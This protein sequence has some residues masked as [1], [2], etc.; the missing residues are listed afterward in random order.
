MYDPLQ[1]LARLQPLLP[2]QLAA[3]ATVGAKAADDAY[4]FTCIYVH[5]FLSIRN[6]ITPRRWLARL[7]PLL[8]LQLAAA[9]TVG[10]NSC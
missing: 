9:A 1:V 6:C 2:L 4:G 10:A 8:P 7:Q 5:L 3:A